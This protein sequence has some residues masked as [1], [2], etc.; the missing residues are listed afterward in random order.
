MVSDTPKRDSVPS[1]WV[2]RLERTDPITRHTHKLTVTG[3]ISSN[4]EY[5]LTARFRELAGQLHVYVALGWV[6]EAVSWAAYGEG[7]VVA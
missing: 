5:E 2:A 4:T 7:Y 3:T 1:R 6:V